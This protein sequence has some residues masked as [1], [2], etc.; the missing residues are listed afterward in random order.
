MGIFDFFKR[1]KNI[2]NDNGY[3]E[4]YYD[5]G[6]GELKRSFFLKNRTLHGKDFRYSKSNLDTNREYMWENGKCVTIKIYIGVTL[7]SEYTNPRKDPNGNIKWDEKQYLKS[8]YNLTNIDGSQLFLNDCKIN[9]DVLLHNISEL[10]IPDEKTNKEETIDHERS[11][12]IEDKL[13]GDTI[14]KNLENQSDK[15]N[16]NSNDSVRHFKNGQI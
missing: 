7:F 12:F 11:S 2:Y 13:E 1:N 10:D 15:H 6:K 4:L 9:K 14:N 3:N 8:K 5:D 16:L